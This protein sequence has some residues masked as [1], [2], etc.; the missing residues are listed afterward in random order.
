VRSIY[1]TW[2]RGD[3]SSGQWADPEIEFVIPDGPTPGRWRGLA[4]LAS[5]MRDILGAW[6]SFRL[7]A[8]Q[9]RELDGE[10]VLVLDQNSARG[11][12]SGVDLNATRAA[13][14]QVFRVSRGKVVEL[15]SYWDRDRALA[16][17]GLV[18]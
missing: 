6:E 13:G 10:R 15:I 5:A 8:D 9:Y 14:A 2:E 18:E 12:A 4:E 11:K 16:D 17:L 1:A 3:F 7:V